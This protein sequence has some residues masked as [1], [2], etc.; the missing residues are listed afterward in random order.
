MYIPLC[1]YHQ[2]KPREFRPP[3]TCVYRAYPVQCTCN[4]TLNDAEQRL[5]FLEEGVAKVTMCSVKLIVTDMY[6]RGK[7][8]R[9]HSVGDQF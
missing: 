4:G 6:P 2:N 1:Q 5:P 8:T 3:I 9:M 7:C